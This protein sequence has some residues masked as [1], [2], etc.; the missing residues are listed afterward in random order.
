[1]REVVAIMLLLVT[2]AESVPAQE[3]PL[4][5]EAAAASDFALAVTAYRAGQWEAAR[6][7]FQAC[8]DLSRR[9]DLL[10]NLS[11]VAEKQG[12]WADALQLE[13]D[14]LAHAQLTEV[15]RQESAARCLALE[16]RLQSPA[17]VSLSPVAP[18]P[19]SPRRTR[20]SIAIGGFVLAGTFLAAALG[21][22]VAGALAKRDLENRPLSLT[23]LADGQSAARVFQGVTIGFSVVGTGLLVGSI[24]LIAKQPKQP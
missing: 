9:A 2:L 18:S 7:K 15:E 4:D 23:E 12:R 10:R 22:G 13:R 14:F 6:A 17:M 8:Y 3:R 11:F 16:A 20:R 21:A 5:L 19:I 24:V 1:M